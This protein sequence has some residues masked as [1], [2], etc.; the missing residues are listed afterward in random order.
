MT[1]KYV[2]RKPM[3]ASCKNY[4]CVPPDSCQLGRTCNPSSRPR[5]SFLQQFPPFLS[6]PPMSPPMSLRSHHLPQFSLPFLHLGRHTPFL[7]HL[8]SSQLLLCFF[9]PSSF[10]I[11]YPQG[12]LLRSYSYRN[13]YAFHLS[14]LRIKET[15]TANRCSADFY[16]MSCKVLTTHKSC[17]P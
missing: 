7:I 16:N 3:P 4:T 2:S 6:L 13:K 12:S 14:S 15:S 10:P 5:R 9:L 1:Q 17:R 8:F 11:S